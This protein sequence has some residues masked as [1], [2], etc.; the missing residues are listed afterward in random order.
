MTIKYHPYGSSEE[1]WAMD[2][3]LTQP[4]MRACNACGKDN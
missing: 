2:E 1:Y 4:I 3:S